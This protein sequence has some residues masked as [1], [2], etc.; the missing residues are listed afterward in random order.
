VKRI[1]AAFAAV[2]AAAWP[3]AVFTGAGVAHADDYTYYPLWF[4]RDVF[5]GYPALVLSAPVLVKPGDMLRLTDQLAISMPGDHHEGSEVDTGIACFDQGGN[6]IAAPPPQGSGTNYTRTDN[7]AFQWNTSILFVAPSPLPAIGNSAPPPQAVFTCGIQVTAVDSQT[8]VLAPTPGQP[9]SGTWLEVSPPD[10]GAQQWWWYPPPGNDPYI[11]TTSDK[12]VGG[13]EDGTIATD[14][15]AGPS[16]CV[17]LGGRNPTYWSIPNTWQ[18]SNDATVVDFAAIGSNTVCYPGTGSC[19]EIDDGP[20]DDSYIKS[21]LQIQQQYPPPAGSQNG[22]PCGAATVVYST[23][24][25]DGTAD[26]TET[27]KV[28]TYQHHSPVYYHATVPVSQLCGGSRTF[29]TNLFTQLEGGPPIKFENKNLNMINLVRA[30]KTT[31]PS[32]I[33]LSEQKATEAIVE[34]G[35]TASPQIDLASP[36]DTVTAQNAPAGTVEPIGSPVQITV[37]WFYVGPSTTVPNVIGLPENQATGAI[38]AA[39]LTVPP[40]ECSPAPPPSGVVLT[41]TPAGGTIAPTGS[42]VRIKVTCQL[43]HP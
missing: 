36:P 24:T 22:A 19:R 4:T 6:Q 25:A 8:T 28:S 14:A 26:T 10:P 1:I 35:L 34:V 39:E 32:V 30:Q 18:A 7:T 17:Y 9:T 13:V 21:G 16:K 37:G 33:G 31:V 5:K 20:G 12:W 3:A 15:N 11:C 40:P 27:L 38:E 41:Q 43:V 23:D 2:A 29:A 42:A